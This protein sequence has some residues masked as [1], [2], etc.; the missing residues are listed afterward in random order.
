MLCKWPKQRMKVWRELR[1]KPAFLQK[2]S[3]VGDKLEG[4][5]K[6]KDSKES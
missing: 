6:S 3:A 4:M 2:F 1:K 5:S